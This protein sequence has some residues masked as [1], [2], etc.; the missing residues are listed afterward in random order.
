VG[1][2]L[3]LL[4]LFGTR[5]RPAELVNGRKKRRD[6]VNSDNNDLEV[7]NNNDIL[8]TDKS[9]NGFKPDNSNFRGFDNGTR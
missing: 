2:A 4:L 9:N 6:E 7:V 1:F 3:I 8:A 5:Y